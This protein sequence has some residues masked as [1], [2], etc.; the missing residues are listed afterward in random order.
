MNLSTAGE[1]LAWAG[2]VIPL[3]ALAWAAVFY[4][5]SHRREVSHQEYKRFFEITD[6]LGYEG[7]SIASKMAAA[8]ELRKYPQYK[9]VILNICER[10]E[11]TG[12]SAQMLK[13][14]MRATAEFLR[15]I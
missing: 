1:W 14:E 10:T 3:A 6:Q 7:G 12:S 2:V 13:D 4:T 15:S 9:S 8:Y 11:V 5:L